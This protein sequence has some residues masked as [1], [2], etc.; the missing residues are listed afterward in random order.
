MI[1]SK[2]EANAS[3]A[4]RESSRIQSYP[5]TESLSTTSTFKIHFKSD[6]ELENE[7]TRELTPGVFIMVE[8]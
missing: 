1:H 4:T 7:L 6:A 8:P 5:N 3:L 2:G